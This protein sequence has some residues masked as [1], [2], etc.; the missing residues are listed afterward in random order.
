MSKVELSLFK[1][2]KFAGFLLFVFAVF[3]G[4]TFA[5]GAYAPQELKDRPFIVPEALERL[6]QLMDE[7]ESFIGI[8]LIEANGTKKLEEVFGHS[9][10]R[11]VDNDGDAFNDITF[12]FYPIMKDEAGEPVE[13]AS[14]A[15]FYSHYQLGAEM[16]NFKAFA[17]RY[18][19]EYHRE[20]YRIP[21]LSTPEMRRKLLLEMET[22]LF[23]AEKRGHYKAMGNNCVGAIF[24]ALKRAGFPSAGRQEFLPEGTSKYLRKVGLAPFANIVIKTDI[25]HMQLAKS[26]LEVVKFLIES[27]DI[28]AAREKL[29]VENAWRALVLEERHEH[30]DAY[31]MLL[32]EKVSD[33]DDATI[34]RDTVFGLAA[35]DPVLY[36]LCNS[37]DCA[38]RFMLK[39]SPLIRANS[40]KKLSDTAVVSAMRGKFYDEKPQLRA[41]TSRGRG[42]NLQK[43]ISSTQVDWQGM[44]EEVIHHYKLLYRSAR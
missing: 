5:K 23:E 43:K 32:N 2:K 3:S 42:R 19:K 37:S 6:Q 4:G 39:G 17:I 9:M 30:S 16:N 38:D 27:G 41:R 15:S 24:S 33:V 13:G 26:N 8:E 7:P 14:V 11:L 29:T 10:I 34:T 44:K 36:A 18:A 21:V 22:L 25:E 35:L 31:R 28:E 40:K 12:S 20:L 1:A